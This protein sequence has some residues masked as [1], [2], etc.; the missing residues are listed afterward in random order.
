MSDEVSDVCMCVYIGLERARVSLSTF[1]KNKYVNVK[2]DYFVL[3]PELLA[4]TLTVSEASS[5]T[6]HYLCSLSLQCTI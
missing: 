5:Y 2:Q 4:G 3:G 6:H 1:K